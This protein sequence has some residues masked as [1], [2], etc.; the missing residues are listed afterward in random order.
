MKYFVLILALAALAVM[1][2]MGGLGPTYCTPSS[3]WPPTSG[4]IVKTVPWVVPQQPTCLITPHDTTSGATIYLKAT[5]DSRAIAYYWDFGD[6]SPAMSWTNVSNP[7]NIGVQHAYTGATGTPFTATVYV[8]DNASPA[9]INSAK[10]YLVIRDPILGTR[11]NMAIDQALWRMHREMNRAGGSGNAILGY[12]NGGAY[13]GSGYYG[14]YAVNTTAFL[15][16]GHQPDADLNDPNP[17]AETVLRGINGTLTGLVAT[18]V[19]ASVTN[20]HGTFK[21]DGN[22]NGLRTYAPQNDMYMGGMIMDMLVATNQPNTLAAVGG[23]GILNVSYKDIV[24]DMMDDYTYC[25]GVNIGGYSGGWRYG[26]R[27]GDSDGS[28][29]QWAAIGM[30]AAVDKFGLSYPPP[31]PGPGT[32][33]VILANQDWLAAD[34]DGT[35]F[36][37]QPGYWY[38]WGPGAV[39]PSGQVQSVMDGMGRGTPGNPTMWDHAENWLRA[40]FSTPLGYYYGLFSFTKSMLLYPGGALTQLCARD[41]FPS[42]NLTNCIDWYNADTSSGAPINGVA[43]TLVNTQSPDGYWWCYYQGSSDQCYFNTAWATIMLNKTVYASGVPIAV[44]DATPTQIVN[45][46]IVNFTGKNSFDQDPSKSIVKW[47]WDFS[48]TGNG[49]FSAS[50]VNQSGIAISHA[51]PY[52]YNFPVRLRVTDN[53]TPTPQTAISTLNIVITNPPFSPTANAGGPY[54]ICP[55]PAYLP[56]Y[57]NGTA[58]FAPG[59][60]PN[61]N[62]PDNQITKWEWDVLGTGTYSLS[63]STLNQPR[64]DDYYATH[65][66]SGNACSGA[67]CMLGM[68]ASILVGLRVTDN[69]QQSFGV[70]ANLQGTATAQVYLRTAADPLCSKCVSTGQAIGHGAVPG[71]PGY[72]QLVWLETGADHY[73]IYRGTANGGPYTKIGVVANTV[74][75]TGKSIGYTDNGP[76]VAGTTYYYRIAPATLADIETCQSNQASASGSLPK[77]R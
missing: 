37:Y 42:N 69:S 49:A 39:I 16:N 53:A 15:V 25:Q 18:S 57:L 51:G 20:A 10:Y 29:C 67:N 65:D 3:P 13:T 1:P 63:G 14:N 47:E 46:G 73:N 55:Q 68:G 36:G 71:V 26:C 56:F 45:G 33:P 5:T 7:Y 40:N 70:A 77:G 64:V 48:G 76:L 21:P 41:G 66:Q 9:N 35:G 24:Q 11:V 27:Y 60:A 23:S 8:K 28:V 61:T 62:N 34:F 43:K 75:G 44:I 17:Y 4:P 31:I 12:W 30:L 54:S 58:A 74:L 52:P 22:N 50:G 38:P 32:S 6:G 72:I 59:H 19:P 2:A